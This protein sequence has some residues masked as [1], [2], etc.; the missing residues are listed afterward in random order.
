MAGG[1]AFKDGVLEVAAD[2]AGT[3]VEAVMFEELVCDVWK[4]EVL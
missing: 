2:E 3:K 1:E 4:A